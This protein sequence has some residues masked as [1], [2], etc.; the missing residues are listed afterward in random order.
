MG[1]GG[2]YSF[3]GGD[4]GGGL[5]NY[6]MF[7]LHSPSIY[8]PISQLPPPH[9]FLL[10]QS[11]QNS[12]TY[13][14]FFPSTAFDHISSSSGGIDH[15]INKELA[16]GVSIAPSFPMDQSAGV[17]SMFFDTN[18]VQPSNYRMDPYTDFY[19]EVISPPNKIS[20]GGANTR[21]KKI[22]HREPWRKEED[23]KLHELVGRY[24]VR[25]WSGISDGME[26]RAGK[27]CRERWRNYLRPDIKTDEWSN[28][29][30]IIL[31]KAHK[32]IGNK[33]AEIA[34]LLPGRTENGIK[35]HWNSTRRKKT[36]SHFRSKKKESENRKRKSTVL[37]DYIRSIDSTSTSKNTTNPTTSTTVV[38]SHA[39]PNPY[40]S[41]SPSIDLTIPTDEEIAFL[42]SLFGNSTTFAQSETITSNESLTQHLQPESHPIN[43][44]SPLLG[45][46]GDSEFGCLSPL[47]PVN[48]S[49]NVYQNNNSQ[50]DIQYLDDYLLLLGETTVFSDYN[51]AVNGFG[52]MDMDMDVEFNAQGGGF[53]SH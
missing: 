33:W 8:T 51:D 24:G 39:P 7:P 2:H 37:L 49:S 43:M 27:Q 23:R 31:V 11:Y 40:V 15:L 1:S 19:K 41:D 25:D 36:C 42:Q 21:S 50:T 22:F 14:T 38:S 30:E 10:D 9:S 29:E 3:Y 20:N 45:F 4:Q 47:F 34:K 26:G 17:N 35:N 13:D 46:N 52:D 44:T 53:F 5:P 32:K 48:E 12:V 6:Q 16:A 28:D 18:W